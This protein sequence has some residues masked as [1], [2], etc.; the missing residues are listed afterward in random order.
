[1]RVLYPH[2]FW[3][4]KNKMQT[5]S[6][7][8]GEWSTSQLSGNLDFLIKN[9]KDFDE[10]RSAFMKLVR[11]S[12]FFHLLPRSEQGKIDKEIAAT[13]DKNSFM[14]VVKKHDLESMLVT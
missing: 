7:Y 12:P 9:P 5:F 13:K 1:M 10:V 3:E 8:L 4:N 6:Q 2:I 11:S 14:R